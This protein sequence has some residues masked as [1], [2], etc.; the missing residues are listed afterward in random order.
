M[1]A[2]SRL[3]WLSPAIAGPKIPFGQRLVLTEAILGNA[4]SRLESREH[5]IKLSHNLD[6]FMEGR[7]NAL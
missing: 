5:V 2:E 1:R 3:N 4:L 7:S 6:Q